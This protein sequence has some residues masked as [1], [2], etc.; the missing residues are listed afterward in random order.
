MEFR[1]HSVTPFGMLGSHGCTCVVCNVALS[2]DREDAWPGVFN[3]LFGEGRVV[4]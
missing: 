2:V 4:S 3:G 1:Y